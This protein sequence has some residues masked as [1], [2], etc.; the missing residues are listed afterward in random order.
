MTI[1]AGSSSPVR[2]SSF[3]KECT[4]TMMQHQRWATGFLLD[5]STVSSSQLENR[6]TAGSGVRPSL[7]VCHGTDSLCSK[8]G[9][10]VLVSIGIRR[11][12]SV[13]Q[14]RSRLY[15]RVSPS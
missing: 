2:I 15:H 12:L 7:T 13:L 1:G 8:D 14:F 9:L 10:S 3:V 6:G 11:L 4:D 5:N